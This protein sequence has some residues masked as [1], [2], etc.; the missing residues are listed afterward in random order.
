MFKRIDETAAAFAALDVQSGEIVT[1]AL[2]S[3]PEAVYA[4]YALNKLGAVANMIH[5]LTGED[6]IIHY[7]NEVESRV[8]VLFD[9]TYKLIG[10]RIG[11]TSVKHAVVVSAGESLLFGLKQFYYANNPK[12]RLP[13][14]S[15]FH[16]WA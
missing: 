11:E 7:L 13:Q 12:V 2:P 3:V 14:N 6:E 5:P 9:G 10:K 1:V 16:S 4:V 15:V 8:A